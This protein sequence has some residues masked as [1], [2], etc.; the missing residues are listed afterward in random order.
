MVGFQVIRF[1][2]LC[3]TPNPEHNV[4]LAPVPRLK[5]AAGSPRKGQADRA[6]QAPAAFLEL[7]LT[8]HHER[9]AVKDY[10]R[11]SGLSGLTTLSWS[12][13]GPR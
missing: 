7:V 13:Q 2:A 12:C 6:G 5:G 9:N 8:L 10:F 3:G 1:S 4:N 11:K